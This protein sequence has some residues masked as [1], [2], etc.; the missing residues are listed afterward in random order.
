M[1]SVVQI[2]ASTIARPR[3]ALF[4]LSVDQPAPPQL[5]QS[6][7]VGLEIPYQVTCGELF[8]A[9]CDLSED[10]VEQFFRDFN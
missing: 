1:R 2:T 10:R 7:Q 6:Q 3:E 9:F 4:E 8:R 5:A